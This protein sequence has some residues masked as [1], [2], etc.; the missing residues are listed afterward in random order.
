MHQVFLP[1]PLSFKNFDSAL[2]DLEEN[3]YVQLGTE[4]CD[5]IFWNDFLCSWYIFS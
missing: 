4:K 1:F 3:K 2:N 5:S